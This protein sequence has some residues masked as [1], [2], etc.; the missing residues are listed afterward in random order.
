MSTPGDLLLASSSLCPCCAACPP[1]VIRDMHQR[2]LDRE[3]RSREQYKPAP[4][5]APGPAAEQS[6]QPAP[7]PP[8][9]GHQQGVEEEAA[10]ATGP[11]QPA[12]G[13]SG[14]PAP[15][16]EEG[17]RQRRPAEAAL[18]NAVPA[19]APAPAGQQQAQ[20]QRAPAAAGTAAQ[21]GP[22][23]FEDRLLTWLALLLV[24]GILALLARRVFGGVLLGAGSGRAGHTLSDSQL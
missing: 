15:P 19:A 3:P 17:L 4:P 16:P 22:S 18:A 21:P 2:M 23:S 14:V 6:A 24:A 11:V 10:H 1:Q 5:A 7:S 20:Q 9:Q 12:G 8:Q 13:E